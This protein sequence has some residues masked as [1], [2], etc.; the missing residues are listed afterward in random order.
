MNK[1]KVVTG[2]LIVTLCWCA[3]K[4]VKTLRDHGAVNE[5]LVNELVDEK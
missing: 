2:A 5:E 1:D 4:M 3:V